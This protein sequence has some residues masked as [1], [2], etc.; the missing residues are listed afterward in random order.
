MNEKTVVFPFDNYAP[1]SVLQSRVHEVWA[2]FFSST[3]KDDLQYTPSDCFETFAFPERWLTEEAL[4]VAG[5]DYFEYRAGL[6]LRNNEGLTKTYHRF[7]D[8]D[9]TSVSIFKL[10][11]L[12]TA[13]DSAVLD[14]Y[15]WRDIPTRCDFILD[16][17]D[18]TEENDPGVR[19]RRK[20]F[21]YRWPNEVR[22]E[23]LARL[24]K[25]NA[26]RAEDER[27]IGLAVAKASKT[28][29]SKSRKTKISADQID[30]L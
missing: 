27:L 4:E 25:L 21:R 10:R 23:V 6:M 29:A 9:E 28:K 13:V 18:P 24:L 20:P 26:E 7:H 3:L 2:V 1:F 12:H 16:Y 14:A 30:L 5:K 8:P 11:E 22:D 15:G 17:E 19:K